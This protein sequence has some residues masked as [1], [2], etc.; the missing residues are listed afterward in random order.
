LLSVTQG[1]GLF[2]L[3]AAGLA[4]TAMAH[5]DVKPS[6]GINLSTDVSLLINTTPTAV[7]D[8]VT[9]GGTPVHVKVDAGSF[10][11]VSVTSLQLTIAGQSLSGDFTFESKTATDG[12][13]V[14]VLGAQH[15]TLK[16]GDP[17]SPLLSLKDGSGA[18]IMSNAGVAGVVHAVI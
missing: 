2:F 14:V 6:T 10:I 17:G 1:N 5:L 8:M 18:L 9:V 15:V 7:D 3:T 16:L 13:K 4:G 11:K 12:S